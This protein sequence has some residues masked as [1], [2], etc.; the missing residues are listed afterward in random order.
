MKSKKSSYPPKT[1]NHV[2]PQPKPAPKSQP[3]MRGVSTNIRPSTTV[4]PPSRP[5]D[6]RVT[7]L[8]TFSCPV[9]FCFIMSDSKVCNAFWTF[10]FLL[11]VTPRVGKGQN[12]KPAAMKQP[13]KRDM[14]NFKNVDSKL[15]NL[16]L[17]EIVDRYFKN[18]VII[19]PVKC[20]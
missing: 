17:S 19:T 10:V 14:R 8:N 18:N 11:K 1:S 15:A 16:I 13:P 2:L 7:L 6:A 4:R 3:A 12:G 5:T 20:S 9:V